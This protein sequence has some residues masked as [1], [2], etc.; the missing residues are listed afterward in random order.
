MYKYV[1]AYMYITYYLYQKNVI[2]IEL[3][4]K[5]LRNGGK[6]LI[7]LQLKTGK[8]QLARTLSSTQDRW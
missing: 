8:Y 7:P 4:N 2:H 3:R 1:Q 5:K 6:Q